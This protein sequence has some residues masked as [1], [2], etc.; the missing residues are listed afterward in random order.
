MTNVLH[1]TRDVL[2]PFVSIEAKQPVL[3][4]LCHSQKALVEP[5]TA[6]GHVDS[7]RRVLQRTLKACQ[8]ISSPSL[9]SLEILIRSRCRWWTMKRTIL[10]GGWWI[11]P[12]K[13]LHR[14]IDA[15]TSYG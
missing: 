3:F 10:G 8:R 7:Q 5:L 2:H 12:E 4:D 14:Q 15:P 13:K 1:R 9:C 6:E 11:N